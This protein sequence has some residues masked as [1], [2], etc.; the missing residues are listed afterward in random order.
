M[1]N[2]YPFSQLSQKGFPVNI[3]AK[4]LRTAALGLLVAAAVPLAASALTVG[5]SDEVDTSILSGHVC[6]QSSSYESHSGTEWSSLTSTKYGSE[7]DASATVASVTDPAVS[8]GSSTGEFNVSEVA[9]SGS[10]GKYNSV[11]QSSSSL[12]GGQEAQTSVVNTVSA[13]ANP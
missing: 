8:A 4:S 9:T 7:K 13:F 12:T 3:F 2:S 10:S 6:Q 11:S 5:V 1:Q